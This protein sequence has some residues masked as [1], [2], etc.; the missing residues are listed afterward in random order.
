MRI[1]RINSTHATEVTVGDN[2][3]LVSYSTPVAARV[4]G[5]GY[6]RT[7]QHYSQTTTKHINA[8]LRESDAIGCDTK[9]QSFFDALMS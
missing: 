8:W 2:T 6:C 3:V 1:R 7:A 9:P 5:H 4:V